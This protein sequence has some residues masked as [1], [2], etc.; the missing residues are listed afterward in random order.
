M[1]RA[2][3]LAN[4]IV[5]APCTWTCKY[6]IQHSGFYHMVLFMLSMRMTTSPISC[7]V[8]GRFLSSC[9]GRECISKSYFSHTFQP[10]HIVNMVSGPINCVKYLVFVFNLIFF[11]SISIVLYCKYLL[12]DRTAI[13]KMSV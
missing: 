12:S 13:I 3:G 7:L 2:F 9:E 6:V 5:R 4:P 11:V 1:I 10:L 8:I